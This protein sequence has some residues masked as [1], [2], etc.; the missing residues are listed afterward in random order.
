MHVQDSDQQFM[1][2]ITSFYLE[3][4]PQA[5][6]ELFIPQHP[7]PMSAEAFPA[8]AAQLNIP[9]AVRTRENM[10]AMDAFFLTLS[11]AV[12]AHSQGC[13]VRLGSRSPK[14]ALG[15][16]SLKVFKAVNVMEMC[17]LSSRVRNDVRWN[18]LYQY[19]PTF[20]VRP[21]IDM[22]PWREFRCVVRNNTLQGI[23]QYHC[24]D[25]VE[26]PEIARHAYAVA[27]ALSAFVS[28][29]VIAAAEHDAFVCDIYYTQSEA[30]LIDYN[31]LNNRT[32]LCFLEPP[33]P[34][35]KTPELRFRHQGNVAALPISKENIA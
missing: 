11:Q 19:P 9:R 27:A 22:E 20:F 33:F 13:F 24:L 17:M 16:T 35:P 30:R 3:N 6:A 34:W 4:L 28:E 10:R 1:R 29:S 31:P 26:F 25:R 23:S 5:L 8:F 7:V 2:S 14:D 32:D 12:E 18:F 21:W 15:C